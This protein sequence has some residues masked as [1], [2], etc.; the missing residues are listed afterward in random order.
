[1]EHKKHFS[2]WFNG[3]GIN[4]T[5]EFTEGWPRCDN[6]SVNSSAEAAIQWIGIY[7]NYS[8]HYS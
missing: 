5:T 3:I 6:D 8:M 4:K 7:I 1:M 2:T